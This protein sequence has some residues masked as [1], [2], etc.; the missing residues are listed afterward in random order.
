MQ[1]R[2]LQSRPTFLLTALAFALA[3]CSTEVDQPG[4][5]LPTRDPD[6]V[7]PNKPV[8]PEATGPSFPAPTDGTRIGGEVY[9][10]GTP[11]V[12]QAACDVVPGSEW[13]LV[14]ADYADPQGPVIGGFILSN[15]EGVIECTGCDCLT[16]HPEAEAATRIVCGGAFVTPGLINAHDHITW[17]H[18]EPAS[19]SGERY[20][21]RNQWRKGIDGHTAIPQGQGVNKLESVALGE[22]RFLMGGATTTIGSGSANKFL[23]NFDSNTQGRLEEGLQDR[24]PV[25]YQTFPLGDGGFTSLTADGCTHFTKPVLPKADG[26]V[27]FPHVSEGVNEA[28][29]NEFDCLSSTQEA[30][31]YDQVNDKAAF[32]HSVGLTTTDIELMAAR[33]TSVVWSPRTNMV[34]Y[35]YTASVTLMARLGVNIALGTDWLLSGSMNMLRE[36][37]CVDSLNRQHYDAAFSDKAI[38][39]MATTN[40]AKAAGFGDR[41]GL[42]RSG[43]MADLSFFASNAE[44]RFYRA[45]LNAEAKDVIMVQRSGL[46]LYG[47]AALMEALGHTDGDC[48]VIDVCTTPKRLCVQ[49]ESGGKT[50]AELQEIAPHKYKLFECGE[51]PRE[52]SCQPMRAERADS[53]RF[54]GVVTELDQD[55]DGV[56]DTADTCP[57]I[58]NPARPMDSVS[59]VLVQPDFD[60]DGEGD[61]CDVCPIDADRTDCPEAKWNGEVSTL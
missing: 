42:L 38:M 21:H 9:D 4:N 27:W 37:R 59:D 28:A 10:C 53:I 51:P 23:R 29:A 49:R 13:Q 48:E 3:A 24:L 26:G 52:P 45:A 36:F 61:V 57:T 7:N 56:P 12:S 17:A 47:D 32:I 60:N 31:A 8:K 25:Q 34:L 18:A 6:A 19:D 58:F 11:A 39:D 5:R 14:H 41:V 35:G 44:R 43:Y 30:G 16:L 22:I 1:V 54:D 40:G 50:L 55:G 20:D 15:P 33:G 2:C 46:P